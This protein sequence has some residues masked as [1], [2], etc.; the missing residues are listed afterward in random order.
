MEDLGDKILLTSKQRCPDKFEVL[1]ADHF[2]NND[3][4]PSKDPDGCFAFLSSLRIETFD[5]PLYPA[6]RYVLLSER[7]CEIM[8]ISIRNL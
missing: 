1:A 7:G 2:K 6:Y 3:C 4:H 5:I 8:E